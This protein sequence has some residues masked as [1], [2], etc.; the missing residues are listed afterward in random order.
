MGLLSLNLPVI[1][2]GSATEDQKVRD[3]LSAL[4]TLANGN[5]DEANVPN[6]A[7]AFGY[8]RLERARTTLSTPVAGTYLLQLS[9]AANN[10]AVAAATAFVQAHVFELEPALFTANAR[11]TKLNLRVVL[12]TNAVAPAVTYNL[13]LYPVTGYGGASGNEPFVNAVG[14]GITGSSVTF[15]T[16][17]ASSTVLQNSGDFT[18]PATGEYVIGVTPSGTAAAGTVLNVLATLELRQV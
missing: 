8:K 17:T 13:A 4:Q 1:G 14:T 16:P 7:A 3:A 18:I 9:N 2:Q 12:R 10:T 6:L 15:T 11:T 5:L